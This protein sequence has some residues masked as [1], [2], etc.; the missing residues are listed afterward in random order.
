M[1]YILQDKDHALGNFINCTP[2]LKALSDYYDARFPVYFETDYVKQCYLDCDFITILNKKPK[3][4]L[5]A[6]S[7]MNKRI[8]DWE[9][10]FKEIQRQMGTN[11]MMSENYRS[12]YLPEYYNLKDRFKK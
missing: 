1:K 10:I 6:S 11:P 5:F 8:P 9:Y 3:N 4:I 12:I 7:M 2:T